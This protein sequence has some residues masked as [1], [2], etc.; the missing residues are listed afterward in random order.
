MGPDDRGVCLTIAEISDFL[1]WRT[2]LE[3]Q[4]ALFAFELRILRRDNLPVA[5]LLQ[6]SVLGL[7]RLTDSYTILALIKSRLQAST[8][9][10]RGSFLEPFFS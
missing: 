5:I 1:G 10:E 4:A 8:C 2:F 7:T 3:C 6:P 9:Q